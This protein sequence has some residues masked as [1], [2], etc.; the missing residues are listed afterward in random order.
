MRLAASGSD[1]VKLR[2]RVYTELK[3]EWETLNCGKFAE[4]EAKTTSINA[5]RTMKSCLVSVVSSFTG[6]RTA[7]LLQRN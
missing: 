7:Y 6:L 1:S 2:E 4:G 5:R 3:P